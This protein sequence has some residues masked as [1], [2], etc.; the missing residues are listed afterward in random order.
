[1][2][3]PLS[4]CVISHLPMASLPAASNV[5]VFVLADVHYLQTPLASGPK[6]SV[7]HR[8]LRVPA[9]AEPWQ[10]LQLRSVSEHFWHVPSVYLV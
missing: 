6:P 8:H 2:P 10:S 5:H 4:V 1:M 3:S 9:L 7:H